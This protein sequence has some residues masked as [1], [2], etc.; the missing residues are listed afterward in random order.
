[1]RLTASLIN[2]TRSSN[3]DNAWEVFELIR[4]LRCFVVVIFAFQLLTLTLY[5]IYG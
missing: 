3:K 5:D 1:M 2:L 4:D